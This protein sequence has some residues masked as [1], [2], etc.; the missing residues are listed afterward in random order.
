MLSFTRQRDIIRIACSI[1]ACL[2]L[3]VAYLT[4]PD[5]Q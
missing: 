4:L 5:W 1:L 3:L 2:E